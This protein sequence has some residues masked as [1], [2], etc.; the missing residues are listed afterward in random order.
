MLIPLV[1]VNVCC[2]HFV[3]FER[4]NGIAIQMLPHNFN[5]SLLAQL[6]ADD[7]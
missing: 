2:Q 6:M 5:L 1:T 4:T 7:I 3:I